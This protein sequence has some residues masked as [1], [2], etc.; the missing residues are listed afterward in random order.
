MNTFRL[1]SGRKIRL[2]SFELRASYFGIG[3]AGTP[4]T[5]TPFLLKREREQ[6]LGQPRIVIGPQEPSDIL[7]HF[8]CLAKL[9]C[10]TP[11]RTNSMDCA[12]HLEVIW[13]VD[14]VSKSISDLIT[15]ILPL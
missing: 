9:K 11:V 12:S 13:W 4:K 6:A 8:R 10:V 5:A 2:D 15:E 1:G 3:L 7:P 14:D